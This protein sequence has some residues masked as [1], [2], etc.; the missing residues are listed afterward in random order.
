MTN[1]PTFYLDTNVIRDVTNDRQKESIILVRRIRDNK[2]KCYTSIFTFMEMVDAE[3]EELFVSEKRND[4]MEYS[5]ICRQRNQIKL[6]NEALREV[7]VRFK[8]IF[9]EYPFI[10]PISLSDKG[11]DLALHIASN[12]TI[13]AP[14]IIHLAA[15]WESDAHILVTSDTHFIKHGNAILKSEGLE[16]KLAICSPTDVS[17]TLTR[18]GF[19][20]KI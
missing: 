1:S 18:L 7:E 16:D 15:A 9:T 2:W 14:D 11:W 10:K 6:S 19:R 5:T 8:W 17:K 4:G 20:V 13:F 3:Q 12:S